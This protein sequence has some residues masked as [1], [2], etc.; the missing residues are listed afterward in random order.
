[1]SNASPIKVKLLIALAL[2]FIA[3][4]T[5]ICVARH[6]VSLNF[7]GYADNI[8][9][10]QLTNHNASEI[11]CSAPQLQFKT[12]EGW[13]NYS[14]DTTQLF[15][16]SLPVLLNPHQ[17]WDVHAPLPSTQDVWRVSIWCRTRPLE[18]H[19][20]RR[21]IE[22]TLDAAS[23]HVANTGFVLYSELPHR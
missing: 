6:E 13:R 8:A 18:V 14:Y 7:V 21:L 19:P 2:A 20:L 5:L 1:M 15:A 4:L 11:Y 3:F 16:T 9:V 17:S 22:S 10:L 12:A 23:I